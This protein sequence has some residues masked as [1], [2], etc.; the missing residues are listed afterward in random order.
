MAINFS[1]AI[2]KI[3]RDIDSFLTILSKAPVLSRTT[4]TIDTVE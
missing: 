1:Q 2:Y 3:I 4:Q